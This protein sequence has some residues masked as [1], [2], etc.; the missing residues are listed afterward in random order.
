MTKADLI[1]VVNTKT[2]LK[3]KDVEVIVNA[4]LEAITEGLKAG[5]KIQLSGFGSFETKDVAEHTGRNPATGESI[6][7]PAGKKVSFSP[8]K[9]MKDAVNNG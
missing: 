5:D 8:A 1:S 9:A 3:K 2:D 4:T 6:T 7:V